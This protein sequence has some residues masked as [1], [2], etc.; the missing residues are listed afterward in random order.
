ML[1]F[2]YIYL[3]YLGNVVSGSFLALVHDTEGETECRVWSQS[4]HG[5][6]GYSAIFAKRKGKDCSG[7]CL[8][9]LGSLQAASDV[10]KIS[11][12]SVPMINQPELIYAALKVETSR[13][14]NSQ[15]KWHCDFPQS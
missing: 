5:C 13:L 1:S 10:L 3:L 6:S 15:Q 14:G 7:K 11:L 2:H 12:A 4:N 9:Q 8:L